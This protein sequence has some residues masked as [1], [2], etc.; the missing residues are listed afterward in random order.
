MIY[1]LYETYCDDIKQLKEQTNNTKII[2]VF[3]DLEIANEYISDYLDKIITQDSDNVNWFFK[4]IKNDLID[5]MNIIKVYDI[6]NDEIDNYEEH[7]SLILEKSEIIQRK[8]DD[9]E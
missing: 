2:G 4:E 3:E 8:E 5:N 9:Y 7:Y 1:V 6:F